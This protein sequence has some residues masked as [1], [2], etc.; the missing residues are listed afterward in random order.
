MTTAAGQRRGW[1]KPFFIGVLGFV[2]AA[3]VVALVA[4]AA[5]Y[6]DQSSAYCDAI[7]E[8]IKRTD[9]LGSSYVPHNEQT[10]RQYDEEC[11]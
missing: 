5:R 4:G 3:V 1:V 10:R 7:A 8:E 9:K 11:R 6:Q 2:V